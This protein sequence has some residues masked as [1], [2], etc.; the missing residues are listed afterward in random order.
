[1]LNTPDFDSTLEKK[2]NKP[3]YR[4]KLWSDLFSSEYRPNFDLSFFFKKIEKYVNKTSFL[5]FNNRS[6]KFLKNNKEEY[7][8]VI[9]LVK[10]NNYRID[11]NFL[12]SL[13]NKQKYLLSSI[14]IDAIGVDSLS[15]EFHM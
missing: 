12:E 11:I 2:L 6:L 1:M 3:E 14:F 5:S 9:N 15:N 7:I 13:D 10:N 4:E 8:E